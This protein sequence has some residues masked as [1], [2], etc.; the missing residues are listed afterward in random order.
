MPNPNKA[1]KIRVWGAAQGGEAY[2]NA[3]R[4][5][6]RNMGRG[7]KRERQVGVLGGEIGESKK[8]VQLGE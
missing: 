3:R 2:S 5:N 7:E 4:A 1:M 8:P 6:L